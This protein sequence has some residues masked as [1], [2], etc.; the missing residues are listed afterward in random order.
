M[1]SPG[2]RRCGRARRLPQKR[3][4]ALV[5]A[6]VC[7][8]VVMAM[9]GQMLLGAIRA[10]RQL[11]IERDR[12]QCELLLQAGIER[13]AHRFESDPNYAGETWKVTS[14]ELLG[15]GAGEVSIERAADESS[16]SQRLLITAEYPAGSERSVRRSRSISLTTETTNPEE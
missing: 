12:R 2:K 14:D 5:T 13:A 3:G 8:L 4:M 10:G 1:N 6:L 11:H 16:D 15:K 9:L 7:L